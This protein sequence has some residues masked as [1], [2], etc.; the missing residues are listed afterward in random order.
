M[1]PRRRSDRPSGQ[2]PQDQLARRPLGV[3]LLPRALP[4][5]GLRPQAEDLLRAPAVVAVEPARVSYESYLRL[6]SGVGDGLAAIQAARLPLPGTP[7][8]VLI[9]GALQYPLARALLT[10]YPGCELWY[11]REDEPPETTRRRRERLVEL[12]IA[13]AQRAALVFTTAEL[14][15]EE[16]FPRGAWDRLERLGIESGRLGSERPDVQPDGLHG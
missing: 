3:V 2:R 6:P 15:A 10:E 16:R 8:C 12:Q 5:F 4:Q 11:V 7:R 13:A 1:Y 14:A 9:F